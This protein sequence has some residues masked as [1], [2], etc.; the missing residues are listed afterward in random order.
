MRNSK[1]IN[2][3]ID[4]C[5]SQAEIAKKVKISA[6]CYQNYEAGRRIPRADIAIRIADA[7]GVTDYEKFRQLFA[8]AE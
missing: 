1:L 4:A 3:R 7:V 8:P 6:I 2:A 5:A